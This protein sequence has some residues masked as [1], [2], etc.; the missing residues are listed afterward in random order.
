MQIYGWYM[1]QW[2]AIQGQELANNGNGRDERATETNFTSDATKNILSF[3]KDLNDK[4]YWTYTGKL[5]DNQGANQIFLAKQA[6]MIIEST[7]AMR[8]FLTGAESGG[9]QLGAGFLPAN[10]DVDRAGVIIG[11]ASLWVGSG[12]PDD[13]NKAAVDFILW[14]MQ[15]EQMSQWHQ[16]TGYMPIT[17]SS[18]DLLDSQGYFND[19]P[20][21][22]I[23]VDQLADAKQTA[24]TAG[25]IM[26]AFPQVRDI[27]EQTIQSVISGGDIDQAATDAKTQADQA[28]SDYNS[29]L[30]SS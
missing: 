27:E 1:E 30:G 7:G 15:P 25:A 24:A 17:K 22:K 4:G 9:F 14:L 8:T 11:G 12:H 28:L 5:H 19:N 21:L 6:A 13:Q 20:L 10:G 23:A 16:G 2:M 3:W 29:R 18:Q 26:G